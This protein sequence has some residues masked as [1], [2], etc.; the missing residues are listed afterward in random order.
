MKLRKLVRLFLEQTEENRKPNTLKHYR[1]RLLHVSKALGSRRIDD[2]SLEDIERALNDA[3]RWPDGSLKAPDTRRAN[4]IVLQQLFKFAVRRGYLAEPFF[5]KLERPRT[6]HRDRIPTDAE[7]AAV[8]ALADPHFLLIFRALRQSAAR[9]GEMAAVEIAHW[10]RDDRMLVIPDHKTVGKTGRPRTI[11]VGAKLEALLVESIGDR[12]SGPIF[13]DPKGRQWTTQRLSA[14]YRKLRK[15]AGLPKDLCLYLQRHQHATILTQKL[16]IEAA[17]QALGHASITTT[18]RYNH[19]DK[20][21]L[22]VNQDQ[23]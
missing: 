18:M 4:A 6:R 15:A 23:V 22:A 7:N 12:E 13:L 21:L 9:P 8:E 17:A 19:P 16:G 14:A 20:S 5:D 3:N 2:L 1:G 11:G 10:H